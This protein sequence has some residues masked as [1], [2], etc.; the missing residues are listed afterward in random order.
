M[1]SSVVNIFYSSYILLFIKLKLIIID[2]KFYR[3]VY[4]DIAHVSCIPMIPV[5]FIRIIKCTFPQFCFCAK[6]LFN[7]ISFFIY[8]SKYRNL[9]S[10]QYVMCMPR[11][12]MIMSER[13][14]MSQITIVPLGYTNSA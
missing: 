11:C 1:V 3:M 6:S 13:L 4:S 14:K 7:K 2:T 9:Y 8:Y 12:Q 5:I 10:T